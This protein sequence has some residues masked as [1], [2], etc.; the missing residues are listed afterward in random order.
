MKLLVAK[1]MSNY[2]L[3][4]F[5]ILIQIFD[6][7]K[8]PISNIFGFIELFLEKILHFVK[9]LF[10]QILVLSVL[11][12]YSISINRYDFFFEKQKVTI[13]GDKW[14]LMKFWQKIYFGP[15]KPRNLVKGIGFLT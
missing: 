2:L 15:R 6:R 4:N 11:V 13:Y 14:I 8:I 1:Q 9:F 10:C 7:L 3:I 12:L 5:A